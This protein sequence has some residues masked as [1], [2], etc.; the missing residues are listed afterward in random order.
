M[1]KTWFAQETDSLEIQVDYMEADTRE[2][3]PLPPEGAG[4]LRAYIGFFSTPEAAHDLWEYLIPHIR[5]WAI[6]N[7]ML[8]PDAI[9]TRLDNYG[10]PIQTN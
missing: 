1:P 4:Y 7:E 9:I 2:G 6:N 3:K 5:Q 10:S 8:E